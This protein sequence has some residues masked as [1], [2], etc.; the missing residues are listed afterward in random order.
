MP[1]GVMLKTLDGHTD[2]VTA[3][4][5]SQESRWLVSGGKDR[6]LRLW[7]TVSG[8]LIWSVEA[9]KA[10][11]TAVAI[12][13]DTQSIVSSSEDG[14]LKVWNLQTGALMH[15]LTSPSPVATP[16]T[17][18]TYG[19][20]PNRVVSANS[21]NQLQVWDLRT[22]QI[23]RTF[24]G[25]DAPIVSLRMADEHTLFSFGEDRTLVWN[26]EQ[27]GLMRAF[28]ESSAQPVAT[29]LNQHR[30]VTVNNDGNIRVWS[31]QGNLM[32][33][34]PSK[35]AK[36]ASVVLSPN[37]RYLVGFSPDKRLRIWQM[38]ARAIP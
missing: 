1:N 26:L 33:T 12:S 18:V 36:N 25:H 14:T 21:D 16:V 37:H 4:D 6:T 20:T 31:P 19:G 35:C 11:I 27:E 9:H 10:D 15:T 17:A 7:D 23:R 24:A 8:A 5:I 13:P 28:P 32:A 30:A 34:M 3:L 22:R 29:L 38:S 2:T